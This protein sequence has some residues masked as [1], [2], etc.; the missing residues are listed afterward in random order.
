MSNGICICPAGQANFT[1]NCSNC[2]G[3]ANATGASDPLNNSQCAC[4]ST[5]VWDSVNLVCT[6][7]TNS[8]FYN[9][10]CFSCIN[11]PFGNNQTYLNNLTCG[12]L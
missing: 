4:I 6:C 7:P 1:G 3:I 2:S 9:G 11:I 10:S 8:F 5:F 12:C